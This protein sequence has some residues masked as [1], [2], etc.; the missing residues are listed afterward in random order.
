MIASTKL[1]L[2]F[3][4][5]SK[6]AKIVAV[7]DRYRATVNAYI[8]HIWSYGGS[9]NK[10]TADVVPLGHLT[11]RM[12]GH[13]LQQALGIVAAT[14]R[15]AAQTGNLATCP[16]FSGAMVLS[17]QLAAI[18]EATETSEFDLW[19]RF[20]TLSRRHCI[21]V[22]LKATRHLRKLLIMP[23]AKLKGGCAI[24]CRAGVYFVTLWV[25]LP[26]LALKEQGTV[27]GIDVGLNKLIA[28]SDGKIYGAD[29]SKY[30]RRV[31][32]CK[33]G[34]KGKFRAR[35]A[36]DQYID[37]TLNQ[38]PWDKLQLVAVEKLTN[39]KKGKK[40][41]RGKSFRRALAPWTYAYVLRRIEWK[42]RL[43]RVRR[44]EVNPAYTSQICPSCTHRARS[45]RVN[46]K[47]VCVRCGYAADADFVGSVN[48][49]ARAVG[50]SMV[51][52]SCTT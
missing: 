2:K 32:R 8:Q 48:F 25:E 35:R 18:T 28:T 22:P 5:V 16:A 9:L 14:R 43:N 1:S 52:R 19:M 38:L 40:P 41:N 7:L 10:A 36:R 3:A 37:E 12:R 47:F 34:S 13:A 33:N 45:N 4:S 23:G 26:D 50:E 44:V 42:A 51:P 31:C 17:K 24:G 11:F 21:N 15:S 6:V 20:S 30:V 27:L 29:M 39:L 46:E 49:L